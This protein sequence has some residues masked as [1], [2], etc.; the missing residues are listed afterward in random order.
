MTA[1]ST[2]CALVLAYMREHGGITPAEALLFHCYRS[3]AR[4][5]DWELYI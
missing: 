4:I 3:S 5:Y 2:Q 1:Y